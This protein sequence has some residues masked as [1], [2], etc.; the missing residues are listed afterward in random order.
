[1]TCRQQALCSS[2]PEDQLLHDLPAAGTVL[3]HTRSLLERLWEVFLY[4]LSQQG[5]SQGATGMGI[6]CT[7]LGLSG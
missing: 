7:A 2:T 5:L 1:M 3:R 6:E 4:S